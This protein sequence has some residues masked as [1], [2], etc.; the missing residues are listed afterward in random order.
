[1]R[2][3]DTD[4]A[5]QETAEAFYTQRTRPGSV[6][7]CFPLALRSPLGWGRTVAWIQFI[8]LFFLQRLNPDCF[9]FSA[10]KLQTNCVSSE[11]LDHISGRCARPSVCIGPKTHLLRKSHFAW[12]NHV[13]LTFYTHTHTGIY[14]QLCPVSWLQWKSTL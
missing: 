3:P 14:L 9:F 12:M 7:C 8:Y 4:P 11:K 2:F 10:N 13:A 5:S 6:W 1:M